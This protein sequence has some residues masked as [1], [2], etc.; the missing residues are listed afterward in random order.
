MPC[1]TGERKLSKVALWILKALACLEQ[2]RL[3]TFRFPPEGPR[4]APHHWFSKTPGE[5]T[6]SVTILK[7]NPSSG[8][9]CKWA[10]WVMFKQWC[11]PLLLTW[12]P[13]L[14]FPRQAWDLGDDGNALPHQAGGICSRSAGW[15]S[16]LQ[17]GCSGE[18]LF[19]TLSRM[20]S[21]SSVGTWGRWT[22]DDRPVGDL[23]KKLLGRRAS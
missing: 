8:Q 13:S 22:Q 2:R 4:P 15:G 9:E 1:K 20:K 14:P 5:T 19:G 23:G 7:T 17:A 18:E 6:F 3:Q 21:Q 12:I 16:L 11:R 10:K